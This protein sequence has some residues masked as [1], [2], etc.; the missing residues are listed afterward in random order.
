MMTRVA[1]YNQMFSIDIDEIIPKI[2]LVIMLGL[3]VCGV[4]F[5]FY[6][7]EIQAKSLLCGYSS[8]IR[9]KVTI[10]HENLIDFFLNRS[11][12]VSF[13]NGVNIQLMLFKKST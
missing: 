6:L 5:F 2:I 4:F 10:F 3:L 8:S 13:A 7:L 11:E 9:I 1:N 12:N